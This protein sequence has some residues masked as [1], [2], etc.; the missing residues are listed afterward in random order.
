MK[1]LIIHKFY[2]IEGG[3]ERYMFNMAAML[4]ENGIEV[5]PF[6][7]QHP[8]SFSTPY[9]DYFVSYFEPDRILKN[10]NIINGT[11]S[12]GRVIY[13][14]EAR[15]KIE[16]LIRDTNPDIAHVHGV[17]HHLSPS[18]LFSLKKY[19]LPVV[20]TLHEYKILCPS[21][22]FLDRYGE[23]CERCQG[24]YFWHP[25]QQ[26]CLKDSFSASALISAE[27]YVHRCLKT[28]HKNVDLYVSPSKF[29]RAKMIQYGFPAEK[30]RWLPYSI[31]IKD[32]EPN[33]SSENYFTYVGRLSKEKGIELLVKAMAH[34]S[35]A[36]LY[37]CGT[38]RLQEPLKQWIDAN[39]I[40]NVRFLGYLSGEKLR[41]V[42]KK[43]MFTVVPSVVYDNS[44]L[45]VYESFALGK[46]VV[47]ARIGGIP[48]LIEEKK[49]GLLFEAYNS[50]DLVNKMQYLLDNR[51]LLISM[52]KA[53]REK[54]VK[55]FSPEAHLK[56]ILKVYNNFTK[57]E[58]TNPK[59]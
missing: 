51:Q 28:Y 18:V 9:Y 6:A 21:Y 7:M 55:L 39:K 41:E 31:P 40:K 53:A 35:E 42:I 4:Q 52:G 59:A 43:S 11:K 54:A 16:K 26:R 27:A 30:I 45:A 24:K 56:S 57:A 33:Y 15:Q 3:A 38:G 13:N 12:I 50:N 29:L 32:Y 58:F 25:I 49:D 17:Y 37:V 46:P 22:L 1:V 20:F 44:P 19:N 48:E 23:I 34:V 14:R 47:G 5:I 36:D 2:F 8:R 10:L